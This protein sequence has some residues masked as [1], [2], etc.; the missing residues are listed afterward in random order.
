M[1][2]T[3]DDGSRYLVAKITEGFVAN[4]FHDADLVGSFLEANGLIPPRNQRRRRNPVFLPLGFLIELAGV[5]RLASWEQQGFVERIPESLPAAAPALAELFQ[6]WTSPA[7]R[8]NQT[9]EPPLVYRLLDI[10]FRHFAWSGLEELHADI[11]LEGTSEQE[12]LEALADFLWEHRHVGQ[13]GE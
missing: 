12:S 7:S 13:A 1:A 8:S 4:A 10:W 2:L 11:A 6:R 3:Q 5:L 9:N